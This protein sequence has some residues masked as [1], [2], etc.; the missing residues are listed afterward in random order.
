MV[1][2][3]VWI[4]SNVIILSGVTLGKGSIIAAGSVVTKSVEPFSIVGGNPAKIIK[5]R[6]SENLIEK[7]KKN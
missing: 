4:G 3:E 2:D 6:L 7:R 1:E 5:F